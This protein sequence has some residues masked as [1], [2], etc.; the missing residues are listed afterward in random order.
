MGNRNN[1]E[2]EQTLGELFSKKKILFI[3]TKNLEYL[4]N[5]QEIN[6]LKESADVK[7]CAYN[8]SSYFIRLL[9]IFCWL[10]THSLKGFDAVFVGFAPQLIVPFFKNK[11][12]NKLLVIDFF[13]SFYDT[14]VCDRKKF[15]KDSFIAKRLHWLDSI[16]IA[17][18]DCVIADTLAHGEYFCTEFNLDKRKLIVLYL[19]ADSSIYNPLV[20]GNKKDSDDFTVLYFGSVLPLQGVEIV[21]ESTQILQNEQH[22]NFVFV[23]PLNSRQKEK[24]SIS[25]NVQFFN[26]LSQKDLAQKIAESDLCLAGHF[27]AEIEKAQRTIPG[28]A[29][30]YRAMQKPMIL[31]GCAANRELY[32]E[33]DEIFYVKQ[34][35]A[36]ALAQRILD[37]RKKLEAGNF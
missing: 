37:A 3:S 27:N 6:I 24:Y 4:R 20:I 21:L 35:S 9:K 28:K 15:P 25:N 7:C 31:G 10:L 2:T 26:W 18:A 11:F 34:G 32:E 1:L 12:M 16:T 17:K 13:I 8:S 33:S 14:L 29:Y 23:G 36:Q 5:T 22:L 19:E 30:I